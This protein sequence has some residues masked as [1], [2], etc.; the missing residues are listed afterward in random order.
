MIE[1]QD[2][3]EKNKELIKTAQK[4]LVDI[5][6]EVH[7]LAIEIAEFKR[8]QFWNTMAFS[9]FGSLA[10]TLAAILWRLL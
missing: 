9:I 2:S 8:R 4:N 6:D 1:N 7:L 10:G 5:S 3:I